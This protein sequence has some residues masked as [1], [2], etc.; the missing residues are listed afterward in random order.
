[1]YSHPFTNE[2]ESYRRQSSGDAGNWIEDDEQMSDDMEHSDDDLQQ[3]GDTSS[4]K[5]PRNC[6][7][8]LSCRRQKTRC[9]FPDEDGPCKLCIK[10]NREC[11]K[12]PPRRRRQKTNVRIA[13]LELKI[14]SLTDALIEKKSSPLKVALQIANK[15]ASQPSKGSQPKQLGPLPQEQLQ[16]DVATNSGRHPDIIDK[17]LVDNDTAFASFERYRTK[18]AQYF[19]FLTISED[20]DI[21]RYRRKRP[22]LFSVIV[23][24]GIPVFRPDLAE[25]IAQY[26]TQAFRDGILRDG[27]R[28]LELVQSLTL[29]VCFYARTL[30]KKDLNFYQ[31]INIAATMAL[32]MNLGR[33]APRGPQGAQEP[34]REHLEARRAWLGCYYM[35][36]NASASYRH[37][38]FL[39]WSTYLE[40]CIDVLST[41]AQAVPSDRFLIDYIRITRLV[42]DA[43]V[44]FAMDDPGS[45][46]SLRDPKT[47]YQLGALERQLERWRK[48]AKHDLAS[49]VSRSMYANTNLYIHEIALHTGHNVDKFRSPPLLDEVAQ[50]LG[51]LDIAPMRIDALCICLENAH[52]TLKIILELDIETLRSLPNLFFVRAGY[53]AVVLKA[54]GD[55][56]GSEADGNARSRCIDVKFDGF[57]DPTIRKLDE[58]GRNGMSNIAQAFSMVLRKVK[59]MRDQS[60]NSDISQQSQPINWTTEAPVGQSS[61][62]TPVYPMRSNAQPFV[63]SQSENSPYGQIAQQLLPTEFNFNDFDTNMFDINAFGALDP[64]FGYYDPTG[65]YSTESSSNPNT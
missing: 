50:S 39:R 41:S 30:Q 5:K 61:E 13:D 35:A 1:M 33:R 36:A 38:A 63:L 19:P 43:A 22:I 56:L 12:A 6:S 10:Y 59:Q 29:F 45:K 32:E 49:P 53:A 18:M 46:V 34:Q 47:Q 62:Q 26:I 31:Y 48:E 64:T 58:A 44:V 9:D 17:G 51:D 7:A 14:Q 55:I 4:A 27:D 2:Q 40:E 52:E 37:P 3:R 42:E 20:I 57:I 15:D 23:L 8:C 65:L 21:E 25:P 24:A 54:L 11:I 60:K 16:P 28:R